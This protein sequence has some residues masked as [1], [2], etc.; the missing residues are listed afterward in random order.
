VGRSAQEGSN[1]RH[2]QRGPVTAFSVSALAQV[3]CR[4]DFSRHEHLACEALARVLILREKGVP[5]GEEGAIP[6][7]ALAALAAAGNWGRHCG[8]GVRV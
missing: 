1:V 5:Y 4:A 6:D 7:A 8:F 3:Q 2:E